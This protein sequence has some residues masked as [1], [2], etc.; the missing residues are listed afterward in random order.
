MTD[1]LPMPSAPHV[2]V[3][4]TEVLAAATPVEGAVVVDGTFGAGGYSRGFLDAGAACVLGIDRDP[5][6]EPAG[7]ALEAASGGR[8]RFLAGRFGD[9]EALLDAAG[10]PAVDVVAFDFGVSSMQLDQAARGFSFRNDGPLDMRMEQAGMTA[11]DFVNTA[12]EH[13][14]ARIIWTY[15]EERASRRIARAITRARPF[16][17]T[18]ALAEAV[19]SALPPRGRDQIDPAT[20]SFQAIRIHV[21]DEL[22][23][24]LRGLVA[25]ERRLK[26]GGRLAAVTFH[27]LEDRLVK[28]FI[29]T[30]AGRTTN[31]SRHV[32]MAAP[33][34]RQAGS[35]AIRGT[36]PVV[37]GAAETDANP[38]SR[39]AKLRIARRTDAPAWDAPAVAD[40]LFREAAR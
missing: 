17:T 11:A 10:V 13:E 4:L 30:R 37:A 22:G 38:R 15:G 9:L 33:D 28:R 39:S 8:F 7:R 14:I 19:R 20:R 24:I 35:F 5:A 23:E 18:A 31:P 34:A 16:E 2:P 1:T 21:N 29:A 6:A 25:A 12:E 27:S 40:D 32:V 36:R 3:L 26:P